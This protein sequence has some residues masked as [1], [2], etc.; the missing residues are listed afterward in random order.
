M[1]LSTECLRRF[2]GEGGLYCVESDCNTWYIVCENTPKNPELIILANVIFGSK[3][4]FKLYVLNAL[5]NRPKKHCKKLN[6]VHIMALF[7][8]IRTKGIQRFQ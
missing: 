6:I 3:S 1:Q 4:N 2:L 5:R 7:I 8:L